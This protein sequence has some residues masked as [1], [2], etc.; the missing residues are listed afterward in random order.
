MDLVKTSRNITKTIKNVNR[1]REIIAVFARH[2]FEEFV[3]ATPGSKI[4]KLVFPK[5]RKRIQEELEREGQYSWQQALGYRLRKAF[6]ELGPAFI[7]FGQLLSSREDLFDEVFIDE[8]K[9]LRDKV[10]GIP[11]SKSKE[12][13]EEALGKDVSDLF[14]YI[15]EDPIGTA[16]IGVVY[17]GRLLTGEPVVIKVRRPNI[18]KMIEVDFSILLFL[19]RQAERSSK[20]IKG[21]GLSRIIK[22]FSSSLSSELNFNTEALNCKRFKENLSVRD[23]ENIFYVPKIYS[24]LTRENVL[25]ME[26]L[27]GI[28]FSDKEK[29][30]PVLDSVHQKLET[31]LVYF[32]KSFLQDGF[33]HADLHGGNFFYLKNG[34]IG[35]IDYGLMG[36]LSRRSRKNFIAIVYA[37]L[38]FNYENLVYEFLDVAE[39]EKSPDVDVLISDVKECL[40]PFVGLTVKQTNFS[41]V[42]KKIVSTLTRHELFLPRDWFIVFRSLMTLDGVGKSLNM[43]ID[44]FGMLNADIKDIIGSTY[45]KNDVL[46][47]LVWASRDVLPIIRIAPRYLKWWLKDFSRKNYQF[48]IKNHGYER[49]LKKIS[50]SINFG[51]YSIFAS[52]LILSGSL[53]VPKGAKMDFFEIPNIS[54]AFWTIGFLLFYRGIGQTKFK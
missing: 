10:K 42:F 28:P 31:G 34:K 13:I 6:E 46:E 52:I 54:F 18:E 15:D 51:S 41:E 29:I 7:K 53:L 9:K 45:D 37:L 47:E 5:T 2:G 1:S 40:S 30:G 3:V 19:A 8:M 22:D 32:L 24:E 44:I 50:R 39:Y 27:D 23:E 33:F 17:S 25:V 43:D 20:E 49:H 16:S 4:P 38:T 11:F 36:S 48:H 35:I 14:E 26:K 21:L 12:V